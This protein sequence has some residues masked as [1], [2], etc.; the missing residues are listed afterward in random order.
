MLVN[1]L[2]DLSVWCALPCVRSY[3]RNPIVMGVKDKLN[4]TPAPGDTWF[5]F[6]DASWQK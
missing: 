4:W 3:Q 2:P 5:K 1:D 6:W